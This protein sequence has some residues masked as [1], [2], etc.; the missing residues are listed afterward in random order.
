M[1]KLSYANPEQTLKEMED[2]E[3]DILDPDIADEKKDDT[4]G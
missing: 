4:K 1:W 3:D 2:D